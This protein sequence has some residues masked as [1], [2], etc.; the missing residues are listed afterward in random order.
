MDHF[1]RSV[2]SNTASVIQIPTTHPRGSKLKKINPINTKFSLYGT[3]A[4]GL[5]NKIDSFENNVDKLKPSVIMLQ[6]TKLYQKG[7]VKLDN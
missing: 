7:L 6:E 2:R 1:G 4:A 3:N 5:G